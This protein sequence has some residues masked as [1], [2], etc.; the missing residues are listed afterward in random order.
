MNRNEAKGLLSIYKDRL[1]RVKGFYHHFAAFAA[2]LSA[3]IPISFVAEGP[4]FFIPLFI[5]GPLIA[6]HANRVFGNMGKKSRQWEEEVLAE[7]IH[8]DITELPDKLRRRA[9]AAGTD[10]DVAQLEAAR[11]RKRL[12]NIEA[13]VT[14]RDWDVLEREAGAIETKRLAEKV[15]QD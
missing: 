13:I 3:T 14:S 2:T 9:I 11:L 1:N 10:P 15:Q 12:E 6:Y 7:L 8:G 5:W 4:V